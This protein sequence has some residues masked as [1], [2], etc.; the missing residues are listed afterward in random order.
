MMNN[1]RSQRLAMVAALAMSTFAAAAGAQTQLAA[2]SMASPMVQ[3]TGS[4]SLISGGVTLDESMQMRR[5]MSQY[6]MRIVMSAPNGYYEIADSLTIMR[7]G[8]VV[9]QLSD[10]GPYVLADLAP[11]RYTVQARF[12]GVSQTRAVSVGGSGTT[13]HLVVPTSR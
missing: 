6:P 10:A 3:Q 11:G 7:N 4:T 8:E 1:V 13:L 5:M 9:A 12:A 2:A